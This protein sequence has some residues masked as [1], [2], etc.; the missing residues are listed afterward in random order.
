MP[1]E[2]AMSRT[3][4]EVGRGRIMWKTYIT[5]F[6]TQHYFVVPY[7]VLRLPL[8]KQTSSNY[9]STTNSSPYVG[10]GNREKHGP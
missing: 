10:V 5:S 3:K 8:T 2:K 7:W 1:H 4:E 9:S 6:K